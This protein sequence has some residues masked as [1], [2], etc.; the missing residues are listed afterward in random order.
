MLKSFIASA[1]DT[2]SLVLKSYL[3]IPET[4]HILSGDSV[5]LNFYVSEGVIA[6]MSDEFLPPYRGPHHLFLS[7]ATLR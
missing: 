4:L 1:N 2:E 5:V 3:G 7:I 6:R